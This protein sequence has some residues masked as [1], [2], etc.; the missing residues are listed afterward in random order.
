MVYCHRE[1]GDVAAVAVDRD[2]VLE[3]VADERVAD[4]A[5]DVQEGLRREAHAP[6]E[7]HVVPG[8]RHVQRGRD[9]ELETILRG[10][11]GGPRAERARDEAVGVEGH[12]VAVLLGRADRD[13]DGVDSALAGGLDL[14]PGEALE[15]AL[16]RHSSSSQGTLT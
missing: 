12:V 5:E 4:L 16:V 2:E 1:R 8:D 10:K 3:A 9:E 7:L 14:R 6:G 15:E 13:Q 11:L